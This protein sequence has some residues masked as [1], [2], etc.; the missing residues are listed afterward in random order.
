MNDTLQL[1]AAALAGGA[2]IGLASGLMMLWLGRI[3]GISGIFHGAFEPTPAQAGERSWRIAF[4]AGLI[5]AGVL[6]ALLA[7]AASSVPA[8]SVL[9]PG[10]RTL[11]LV[12]AGLLVGF[13]TRL[14]SGCTSGH[15]VCGLARLSLR[16][17]SAVLCFMAFGVATTWLIRHGLAVG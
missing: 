11:W 6:L 3:A 16:S 17:L 15:G 13:G 1:W 7:P 4:V 8:V 5:A 9:P 2:I 14:G 10:P 12:L